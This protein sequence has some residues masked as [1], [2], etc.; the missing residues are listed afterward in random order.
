MARQPRRHGGRAE[1]RQLLLR[2]QAARTWARLIREAECL[3]HV[4]VRTLHRLAA[5]ELGQLQNEV[6]MALRSRV[7]SWLRRFG[8]ATRLGSGH[9]KTG[10]GS[11]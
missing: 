9:K 3:W 5:E 8:V 4:D 2:W 11:R 7:N 10:W 6:P 1:P